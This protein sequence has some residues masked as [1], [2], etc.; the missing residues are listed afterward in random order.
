MYKK[1]SKKKIIKKISSALSTN[2]S[3]HSNT[4]VNIII[5][6]KMEV[7]VLNDKHFSLQIG[8]TY[9]GH[10]IIIWLL[11]NRTINDCV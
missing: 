9:A 2:K 6:Y 5:Y 10:N 4:K 3:I 7:I 8:T 1:K 11:E